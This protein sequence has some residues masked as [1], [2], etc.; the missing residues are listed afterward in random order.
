MFI[1][2]ENTKV[3]DVNNEELKFMVENKYVNHVKGRYILNSECDEIRYMFSQ[4]IKFFKK[5][6]YL[7]HIN[8]MNFICEDCGKPHSFHIRPGI[9]ENGKVDFHTI[10]CV[11]KECRTKRLDK[12]GILV[13]QFR[14]R[15]NW[16]NERERIN[17]EIA[18]KGIIEDRKYFAISCNIVRLKQFTKLVLPSFPEYIDE[19]LMDKFHNLDRR[20]GDNID[21]SLYENRQAIREFL[22]EENHG[23]CPVCGKHIRKTSDMTIDHIVAKSLGGENKLD[24]FIGMCEDCN[25]EKDRLTVLEF[26]C[27]RELVKMP[28]RILRV[29][30]MQQEK[31][32]QLIPV[33]EEELNNLH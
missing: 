18:D 7:Q 10:I 22:Y 27:T 19:R 24:N 33:K 3:F 15:I 29:A 8:E 30:Y 20:L 23:L 11:C 9:D 32:K 13:P 4:K 12:E 14:K 1:Y 25:V 16:R 26:L 31:I 17:K 28:V 5:C 21:L 2:L 6:K